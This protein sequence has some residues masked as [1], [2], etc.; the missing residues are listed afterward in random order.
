MFIMLVGIFLIGTM[1]AAFVFGLRTGIVTLILVRP[2]CDRIFETNRFDVAGQA[3]SYGAIINFVVICAL[4]LN[5]IR[6]WR[7]VPFAPM[8]IWLPFLVMT[9]VAVFY[10]P[11]Q[12]DAFRKFLTYVTFSGMLMFPFLVVK[13]QRD[14]LFFLKLVILSSV[15]PVLYGLFQTVSGIDWFGD[16]RVHSTFSH[17]NIF[18][19][20]L[21][22]IIGFTFFLLSTELVRI[23]ARFRLVLN[24]YLIP[25]LVLLIMTKTRNAWIGCLVL[26]FV[27]GVVYDRRALVFVLVAPVLALVVPAVSE[28]IMD[29]E[30]GNYY[31][32]G[33]AANLN[34]YAWRELLWDSSF[35][36]IWQKPI[37]GYGLDSF[38]FYS[39]FFFEL[40]K[41]G[42]AP[43]NVYIQ[44]LFETGLIG[45]VSFLWIFWWSY[46]W[47]I[48]Y[49][50]FDRRGLTMA[51]A[52]MGVFLI[53]CY[54]DNLLEYLSYQWS[55]WFGFGLVFLRV[56]QLPSRAG[57]S[58]RQTQF[59]SRSRLTRTPDV[60]AAGAARPAPKSEF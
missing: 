25:L 18:A 12:A 9:F 37:F 59:A 5:I 42:T 47:L 56:A 43:H 60:L 49:W 55:F 33:N 40:E 36:Y 11:V 34:A 30:S 3:I 45:M 46:A 50:R 44:F 31:Y 26:F 53:A 22:S 29:L 28:R 48:R 21:L 2:L 4:L 23:S 20:Y 1:V 32:G 6:V 27:Y 51:A 7:R 19:F 58:T 38:H 54:S 41:N 57:S 15:L 17:P 10:S 39:P 52:M 14:I 13:S 16:S 35:T 8:G 24:I